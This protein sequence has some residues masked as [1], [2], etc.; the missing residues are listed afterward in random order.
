MV[1]TL[2]SMAIFTPLGKPS[3]NAVSVPE[4][5]V[6]KVY[7]TSDKAVVADTVCALEPLV[8][9]DDIVQAAGVFAT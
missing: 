2:L 3:A 1:A 8:K 7:T 4:Q 6:E 5:V 9:L